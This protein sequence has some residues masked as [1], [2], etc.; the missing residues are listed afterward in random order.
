MAPVPACFEA[1]AQGLGCEGKSLWAG[2]DERKLKTHCP[3][4][5]C[6][7]SNTESVGCPCLLMVQVDLRGVSAAAGT[8]FGFFGC[9]FAWGDPVWGWAPTVHSIRAENQNSPP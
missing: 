2:V 3:L 7:L 5:H 6:F 4:A 9:V 8:R 1:G